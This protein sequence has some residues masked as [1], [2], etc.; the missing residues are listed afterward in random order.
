MKILVLKIFDIQLNEWLTFEY[1]C[2]SFGN[3]LKFTNKCKYMLPLRTDNFPPRMGNWTRLL[4]NVVLSYYVW[5]YD[6]LTRANVEK[7]A[8]SYQRCMSNVLVNRLEHGKMQL[9]WLHWEWMK[10]YC[11]LTYNN[12]DLEGFC[13]SIQWWTC[14]VIYD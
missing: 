11:L 9:V 2:T 5:Y 7:H 13:M 1:T 14:I 10:N 3:Q 4:K 12:F 8:K 6:M